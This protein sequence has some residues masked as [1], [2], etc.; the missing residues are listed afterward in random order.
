MSRF[1]LYTKDAGFGGGANSSQSSIVLFGRV[2]IY[3]NKGVWRHPSEWVFEFIRCP[4]GCLMLEC[5]WW[6]VSLLRGDHI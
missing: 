1:F 3:W 4:S 5:G 2:E 6:G